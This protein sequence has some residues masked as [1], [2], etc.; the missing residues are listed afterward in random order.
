VNVRRRLW[1]GLTDQI[2]DY[3][4]KHTKWDR[5]CLDAVASTMN[6]SGSVPDLFKE[7]LEYLE[8]SRMSG[9]SVVAYCRLKA[10][11]VFCISMLRCCH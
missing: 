5:N 7:Y 8:D 9:M 10:S 4:L 6:D 1:Q 3:K 11:L 2:Q